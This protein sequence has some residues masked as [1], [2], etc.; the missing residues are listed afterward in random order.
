ADLIDEHYYRRSEWFLANTTRYDNYPRN[1]SKI[2]AGEYAAQSDQTVNIKGKNNMAT[3]IAEAAFM[4]GLERNA[5]VVNMASYAPL[6]AHNEAWQC[7]TNLIWV[8]NVQ[9]YGTT[10]Y[11]VQKLYSTNKGTY[12][13]P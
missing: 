3:A 8:N 11:Y 10:D 6:F 9:S 5:E 4:T 12:V 13:V 2:F 1:G 7:P